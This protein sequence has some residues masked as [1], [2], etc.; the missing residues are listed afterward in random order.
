MF[1]QNLKITQLGKSGRIEEAIKLFSLMKLKNTV[2]YNSMISAYMKNGRLGEAR[3]L[4][5]EMP[6][7][8]LV[9]WNSVIAGYLHNDKVEEASQLFDKMPKRELKMKKRREMREKRYNFNIYYFI[10]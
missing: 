1:N 6:H 7:P 9:S 3:R 2:S 5:D 10:L 8:N 4:F